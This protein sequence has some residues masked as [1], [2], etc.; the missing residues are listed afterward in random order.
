MISHNFGWKKSVHFA[1]LL[2]SFC[3]SFPFLLSFGIFY[4]G[5][6]SCNSCTHSLF[7]SRSTLD[8]FLI[9]LRRRV[10][11]GRWWWRRWGVLRRFAVVF[12]MLA[13]V[14]TGCI[15]SWRGW[16]GWRRSCCWCHRWRWG[17]TYHLV[18][19]FWSGS[20]NRK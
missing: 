19:V 4:I 7:A 16:G 17:G 1:S 2:M 9:T 12:A 6:D 15:G 3:K 8:W 10:S 5:S 20:W 11:L 14:I 13:V 18:R